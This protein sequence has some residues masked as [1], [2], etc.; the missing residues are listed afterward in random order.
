M[1]QFI[2]IDTPSKVRSFIPEITKIVRIVVMDYTFYSIPQ[3]K[4]RRS[5]IA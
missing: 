5:R 2:A 4:L 3:I 1:F